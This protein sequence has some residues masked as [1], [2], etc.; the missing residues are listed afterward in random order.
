MGEEVSRMKFPD[1]TSSMY[2]ELSIILFVWMHF[3]QHY[4][5]SRVCL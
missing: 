4:L 2:E 5:I 1:S 3:I